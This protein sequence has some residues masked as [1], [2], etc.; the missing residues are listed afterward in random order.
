[1]YELQARH[2][3]VTDNRDRLR[4]ELDRR[5]T[6]IKELK[7]KVVDLRHQMAETKAE[8]ERKMQTLKRTHQAK[9]Q[10]R[11]PIRTNL[12]SFEPAAGAERILKVGGEEYW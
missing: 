4:R 5:L 7:Q 10:E 1:M 2:D 3:A 9:W 12:H 11:A 6:I 8:A